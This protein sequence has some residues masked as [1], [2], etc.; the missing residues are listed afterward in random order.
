[1]LDEILFDP[2]SKSVQTLVRVEAVG[3]KAPA[4]AAN[5]GIA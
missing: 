4:G 1:M 2:R 5:G 3:V